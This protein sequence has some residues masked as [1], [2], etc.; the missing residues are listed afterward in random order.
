MI[1]LDRGETWQ[2]VQQT[3]HA[4]LAGAMAQAWGNSDFEPPAPRRTMTTATARHDDGWAIWERAPSLLNGSTPP[5]PRNFLDVEVIPHLAFYRAQI[6]AV[7]DDDLYAAAL[8]AMHGCGIYNGRYGT[9]P[10]LRLTFAVAE[11][12]A[13]DQFIAEQEARVEAIVEELGIPD[14]ERWANY[15]LLQVFDRLSLYFCMHDLEQHAGATLRPVPSSYGGDETE[16]ALTPVG[17]WEVNVDP[18]P[19]TT[20]RVELSLLSR[21]VPKRAW[22]D[23]DDFRRDFFAAE[24]QSIPV[25][26]SR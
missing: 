4:M 18:Y 19:F 9:D 15:R 5:R 16:L 20:D 11:R 7:L 10:A 3:D 26:L 2:L 22:A 6:T 8:I 25:A 21:T 23:A 13:V 12:E 17:P 1:V 24:V 14:T